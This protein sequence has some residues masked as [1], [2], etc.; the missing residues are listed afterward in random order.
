MKT[1]TQLPFSYDRSQPFFERLNEWIGDV[2]YDILPEAGL[3]LRDEQIFMAFQMEKAF[4]DKKIMFAEAGVGTGKTIAYLLYAI[5]YARYMRKPAIIACADES[6]I[7]QLVKKDGDIDK[8]SNILGLTI[9]VRLAKSKDQYLCLQKLDFERSKDEYAEIYDDIHVDLPAFVHSNQ[10]L[11]SFHHYGDRK[12][13]AHLNNEEWKKVGWDSFQD[14]FVCDKRHRCG[15]TLSREHYRK[16]TDLLICSHDF[17]MEHV[18]T[19]DSRIREGQLPLLP[20]P[21]TVI[22][23]EGHLLEVAAQKALTYKMRHDIIEELLTRLLEND[24]REEFAVLVD[25][26]ISQSFHFSY[27][28]RDH[29]KKVEGSDRKE[30]SFSK[31]LLGE[32]TRMIELIAKLE[33]EIVFESEMYTI[34]AYQLKIVE[35]HL[36]MIHH[37]L[38]IFVSV[39]NV[40][41]WVEE[42]ELGVTLVIMPRLVEEVLKEKVFLKKLPFLFTSATLSTNGS[43]DYLASSIGVN[44]YLSFSVESPFEYSEQMELFAP[45]IQS[46]KDKVYYAKTLLE[47]TDGKALLLFRSEEELQ[48]FKQLTIEDRDFSKWDLL[49]E[50]DQEISQLISNFQQETNSVLCALSLWEGLD[51]PGESLSNV[52]IWSLPFPPNDPVFS[53]KRNAALDSFKEVDIPYMLLRLRQGLGRLIRT[54]Q[55]KGIATIFDE[56]LYEDHNLLALV[57]EILPES[58]KLQTKR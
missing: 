53:A 36:D 4:I 35:E 34:D 15:L 25:E 27:V 37:A 44:D 13:Y 10:T 32:A 47:E 8:L 14:C 56:Q 5:C 23:D 6:L 55:D 51:I 26:L 54:H 58:V 2:F 21:S 45:V 50:G 19:Y 1:N 29:S 24:V 3:E 17:Y 7:E 16:S 48:Q 42:G 41:S 43:F 46:V 12:E 39:E 31:E 38:K 9:D 28:L 22:F 57:K 30:I 18:W 52:I 33:D 49:F 20:E 11:Q 40:I